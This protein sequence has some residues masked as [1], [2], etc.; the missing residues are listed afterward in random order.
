[1]HKTSNIHPAGLVLAIGF[2]VLGAF[3]PA[4]FAQGAPTTAQSSMAVDLIRFLDEMEALPPS[5]RDLIYQDFDFTAARE[6]LTAL[7]PEAAEA[8]EAVLG[9]AGDWRRL[10][11]LF[12]S[13]NPQLLG[14]GGSAAVR[15]ALLSAPSISPDSTGFRERYFELTQGLRQVEDLPEDLRAALDRVDASVAEM[16][17]QQLATVMRGMAVEKGR[18]LAG[19]DPGMATKIGG[20]GGSF[21]DK[22]IC[23]V[24]WIANQA[25]TFFNSLPGYIDTAL[26]ELV[27]GLETLFNAFVA[28]LPD[29]ED[30]LNLLG[31]DQAGWWNSVA[32]SLP[33][34]LFAESSTFDPQAGA[35][36]KDGEAPISV[37]QASGP[38]LLPCMSDGTQVPLIG[39]VGT[40]EGY[41]SCKLNLEWILRA[42]FKTIPK[43]GWGTPYKIGVGLVYFPVKYLCGC[44]ES[45]LFQNLW[46]GQIDHIALGEQ[47]LDEVVSTRASDASMAT[48]LQQAGAQTDSGGDVTEQVT[49]LL[50][51]TATLI[52]TVDAE[53]EE[54]I[55]LHDARLREQ[56]EADL[57][58]SSGPGAI[59]VFLL[60]PSDGLLDRVREFVAE[61]IAEIT[62]VG[63]ATQDAAFLLSQAD[64]A[65]LDG[66]FKEAH[67]LLRMAYQSAVTAF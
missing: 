31:L 35:L 17:E 10:P 49:D 16:D 39:T 63:G 53:T 36:F 30:L 5:A 66:N 37:T 65:I 1:M 6:S 4:S 64:T 42:L 8:L 15:S 25:A 14:A 38:S 52:A 44:F 46:Q 60:P 41:Y 32:S 58:F 45:T 47:M 51:A 48:A 12:E 59:G 21:P 3:A 33:T 19:G 7:P 40:V 2:A 43:D 28:L 13:L 27:A 61:K 62:A 22:Q 57:L 24:L 23:E 50:S 55:A 11:S 9:P 29:E 18:L 54:L 56:I 20:C 34:D 26:D 67:G